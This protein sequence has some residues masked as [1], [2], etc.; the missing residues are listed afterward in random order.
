M[1][2]QMARAAPPRRLPS[3]PSSSSLGGACPRLTA[4]TAWALHSST[5]PASRQAI[6]VGGDAAERAG[7]A[8]DG[9]RVGE[10]AL[11]P[12]AGFGYAPAPGGFHG[13]GVVTMGRAG[14]QRIE[15]GGS[16]FGQPPD[17]SA[18]GA[19]CIPA[20]GI[21]A[22]SRPRRPLPRTIHRRDRRPGTSGC[23]RGRIAARC[24]PPAP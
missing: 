23:R 15:T 18:P 20:F 21:K 9:Q 4:R 2:S 13:D 5:L 10:A 1:P 22:R 19:G 6:E 17:D 7:A 11:L 12:Q 24:L 8:I 14:K 3:T 16:V